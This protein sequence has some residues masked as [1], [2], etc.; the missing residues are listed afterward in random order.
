M[1]T[2]YLVK[3][4]FLIFCLTSSTDTVVIDVYVLAADNA[5]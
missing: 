3:A 2:K 5:T 1:M 4:L